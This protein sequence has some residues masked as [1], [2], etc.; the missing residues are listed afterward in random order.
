MTL[1]T[2]VNANCSREFTA[3]RNSG[4]RDID[5]IRWIFLHDAEALTARGVARF[6]Q[7][8]A[9]TG[10]AHLVVDDDECYRTLSNTDIPWGAASA[11]GANRQG[12]HIEQCGRASW[13]ENEWLAHRATIQRAAFKTAWHCVLFNIPPVFVFAAQLP[14]IDGVSTHREVT[15]ASKRL[16]PKHASDYNHTDPGLNWPRRW[17]MSHVREYFKELSV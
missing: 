14:H 15:F 16:D 7:S 9:A 5:S 8:P 13:T 12:F 3:K 11:F 6:F 4:T 1:A 10:S 17:F 2:P